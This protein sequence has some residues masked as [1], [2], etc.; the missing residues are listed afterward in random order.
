MV[1]FQKLYF[2]ETLE[3]NETTSGH[4]HNAL[5]YTSHFQKHLYGGYALSRFEV[6]SKPLYKCNED[7]PIMHHKTKTFLLST[8]KVLALSQ[9]K[10][11]PNI[12]MYT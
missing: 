4:Q 5:M 2:I 7:R 12:K 3:N 8:R 10:H 11:L 1:K 6:L 9:A